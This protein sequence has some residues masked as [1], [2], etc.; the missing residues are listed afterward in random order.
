MRRTSIALI[1][2]LL[3]LAYACKDDDNNGGMEV[4]SDLEHIPYDPQPY[5]I[6]EPVDFPLLITPEDNPTTVDGVRLGQFL[7][8]DP[9]LSATNTMSCSSCHLPNLAFT[10]GKAVSTGIDGI[11]G[12]RSSMSLLNAAYYNK[13]LFWDG[14][15]NT[16][17][18][19]ALLPVIDPI[20]LH[21][22]WPNVENKFR[23]HSDYPTM[24][25]KA[26]G[27]SDKSEITKDLAVKALAQF[28]RILIS[29]NSR[30][31][32]FL[33]GEAN[34]T[35]AERRG[36]DMFFDISGNVPDAECSH[37]HGGPLLTTNDYFNNGL[38]GVDNLE[39][40]EDLGYGPVTG[41]YFDNGRFRAPT[42]R[43]IVLTAPYMH[44]G[45]FETLEEVIDHYNSGGHYAQN[46][47]P[48]IRKLELTEE[49]KDQLLKFLHTLTDTSYMNNPDVLNPFQ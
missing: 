30:F 9:I 46:I 11:A 21:D 25:R 20:E 2:C 35:P 47:D 26:F 10:D 42:L 3:F 23:E 27:I 19:Q 41:D 49:D 37:C 6:P 14:R 29:G 32:R 1:F 8:Y 45:R 17:E 5:A 48:L 44:D 43:N 16:L 24:F 38:D 33:R 40:F 12:T 4:G 39:D 22:T 15:S 18:E 13:G 28:E 36:Y 34:F 31:D 7:F